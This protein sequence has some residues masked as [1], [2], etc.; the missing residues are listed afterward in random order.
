MPVCACLFALCKKKRA[1]HINMVRLIMLLIRSV[2]CLVSLLS[3]MFQMQPQSPIPI[4]E[5][6]E[7]SLMPEYDQP[8]MYVTYHLHLSLASSLPAR[9]KLHLPQHIIDPVN[10]S[11]I[12]NDG[13]HQAIPHTMTQENNRLVV[14]FLAADYHI[15]VT[16]HDPGLVITQAQRYYQFEWFSEINTLVLSLRVL[17]PPQTDWFYTNP[18]LGEAQMGDDGLYYH[19]ALM[20]NI[21]AATP[22]QCSLSYIRNANTTSQAYQK[23]SAVEEPAR[24][25]LGKAVEP[26]GVILGIQVMAAIIAVAILGYYLYYLRTL[27]RRKAGVKARSMEMETPTRP[28]YYCQRCGRRCQIGDQFCRNCGSKLDQP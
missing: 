11:L 22:L 2:I 7:I 19:Y 17:Q 12:S 23:I 20:G 10:I 4:Y 24:F 9:I 16:Y 28:L 21:P 15:N 18:S 14:E 5:R 27:K 25:T 8:D 6:V 3:L 13:S 26:Q 1:H